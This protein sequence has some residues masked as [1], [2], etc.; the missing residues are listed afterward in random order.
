MCPREN[1]DSVG[2]R[3]AREYTM[4]TSPAEFNAVRTVTKTLEAFSPDEQKR[5]FG[6]RQRQSVL[7][8]RP[9]VRQMVEKE[10]I[11]DRGVGGDKSQDS[12]NSVTTTDIDGLPLAPAIAHRP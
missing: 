5:T 1:G 3:N 6:G 8:F 9:L 11:R 4:T 7:P 2:S 12:T 10:Q